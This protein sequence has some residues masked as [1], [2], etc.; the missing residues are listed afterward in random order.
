MEKRG[1]IVS[2]I[3]GGECAMVVVLR[4]LRWWRGE[5]HVEIE[6]QGSR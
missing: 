6:M 3:L 1:G 2:P 4:M 5:E